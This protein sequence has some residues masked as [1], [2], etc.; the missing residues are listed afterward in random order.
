VVQF[1]PKP[2]S[3][4]RNAPFTYH[5]ALV[6]YI[7]TKRRKTL[8]NILKGLIKDQPEFI[9]QLLK[10][11]NISGGDLRPEDVTTESFC[12]LSELCYHHKI[13]LDKM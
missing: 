8:R 9:D 5:E 6:R 4:L 12:Q 7:F 11:A 10:E 13:H 1:K 2:H 3:L